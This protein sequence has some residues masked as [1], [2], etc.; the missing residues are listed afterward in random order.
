MKN[1]LLMLCLLTP[2]LAHAEDA[3]PG[4]IPEDTSA[5]P[6]DAMGLGSSNIQ[7]DN[8]IEKTVISPNKLAFVINSQRYIYK[9]TNIVGFFNANKKASGKI[10]PDV[11]NGSQISS[12][13]IKRLED[14]C[15]ATIELTG[16]KAEENLSSIISIKFEGL[17][18]DID[19]SSARVYKNHSDYGI[20]RKVDCNYFQTYDNLPNVV[21]RIIINK[22]DTSNV[23]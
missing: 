10:I 7:T 5:V 3:D 21:N 4:I 6:M 13:Y 11:F 15:T 18:E 19:F 23:K 2:L 16:D 9:S 22:K 1:I 12:L 17:S 8:I 20:E 14:V